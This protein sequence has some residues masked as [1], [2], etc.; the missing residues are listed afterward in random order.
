MLVDCDDD[1]D[2]EQNEDAKTKR[3]VYVKREKDTVL[4][5]P[6][7]EITLEGGDGRKQ[8]ESQHAPT[9]AAV[10]SPSTPNQQQQQQFW[11]SRYLLC[12]Y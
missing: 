11:Y 6:G 12:M 4:C 5:V 9:V 3:N 10:R 8:R 2:D 1:D 7:F